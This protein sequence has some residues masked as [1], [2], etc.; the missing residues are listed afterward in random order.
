MTTSGIYSITCLPTG[1]C[2]IGSAKNIQ[3]RWHI[4]RCQ[5]RS[6][7]HHSS[8]LQA[9]WS[10]HGEDRFAFAVL[11]ICSTND[12]LFYEQRAIA[13]FKAYESGLNGLPNAG[14]RIGCRLSELTR[15][16]ISDAMRGKCRGAMPG[17]ARM[18][19]SA[20]LKGK[21]HG[22]M[23]PHIREKIRN[24]MRGVPQGPRTEEEKQ[25]I[26]SGMLG[27]TNRS[28]FLRRKDNA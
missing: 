11:F 2:Y 12:L 22:P 26:S 19:I 21:A 8:R 10:K 20:A 18:K 9:T 14:S 17:E 24:T 3:K 28:D 13:R 25:K 5:L 27:N 7:K 23:D 1:R 4:H 16:K 6:G 15:K